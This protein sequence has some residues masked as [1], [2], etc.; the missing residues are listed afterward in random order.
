MSIATFERNISVNDD[1]TGGLADALPTRDTDIRAGMHKRLPAFLQPFLTWLTAR[2][3][4]GEKSRPHTAIFHVVTAF[5]ALG[6]GVALSLL[7]LHLSGPWLLALPFLLI[8]SS[9]G[10]GKLQAV[11]F[12]HCAHGTV[13]RKR[14]TNR[15]VGET[16][17][18]LLLMKHF[19]VYQHEHMLHHSPNK[20]LTHEDEFTQFVMNLAGLRP[21][22]PKPVLWRRVIVSFVSPF[23]HLRFL[24]ARVS[25][26]LLSHSTVHNLIGWAAWGGLFYLA[27]LTGAWTEVAVAWL[28]PVTVLLQIGTALRTLCEHRFPEQE[29]IDARGKTFVCLA[30][31]GVFPGSPVPAQSATSP[32]GLLAWAGWWTSMLTVHLFSRVFVL[33]GDA[34]CH[35]FHHRRP[36]SRRW[37]DYIHARQKD[38]DTGCQSFPLGYIE[39]WGLIEAIDENL[40]SLSTAGK[41]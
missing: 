38:A 33:V 28:V 22:L 30:T 24:L 20:L 12:H 31:A 19:D 39:T 10:M 23:F 25:S 7:A 41:I 14:E 21:G 15:L 17:S 11:V 9:S 26:C 2:P 37:T 32:G 29:V 8:L 40:A 3:A 34:P 5:G 1:S 4:P 27:W 35:D 18:I 6:A 36:A 16:I 13:F